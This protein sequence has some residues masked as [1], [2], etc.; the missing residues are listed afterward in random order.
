M[1]AA[2]IGS[3]C[4]R[5]WWKS[6]SI[7]SRQRF[8]HH[9]VESPRE[10][11]FVAGI[12]D[13]IEFPFVRLSLK[14]PAIRFHHFGDVLRRESHAEFGLGFFDELFRQRK[15]QVFTPND[16]HQYPFLT[17]FAELILQKSPAGLKGRFYQTRVKPWNSGPNSKTARERC[18]IDW[19]PARV[20]GP[21]RI[22]VCLA[23]PKHPTSQSELM[24]NYVCK[25][26][27]CILTRCSS[28]SRKLQ[29]YLLFSRI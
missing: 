6:I 19:E 21:T 13:G 3:N 4:D 12:Q 24:R 18:L 7:A 20:P 2:P 8:P 22:L 23:L 5:V 27:L 17:H 11:L 29:V 28:R 10:S 15:R 26:L 16:L 1:I 25:N 9:I 14:F